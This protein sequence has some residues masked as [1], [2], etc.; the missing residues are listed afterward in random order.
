LLAVDLAE[1]LE[2]QLGTAWLLGVLV[3]GTASQVPKGSWILE[4]STLAM[5]NGGYVDDVF[6]KMVK[7]CRCGN[8]SYGLVGRD[9]NCM[10]PAM[11][12]AIAPD[13]HVRRSFV[14]CH[15]SFTSHIQCQLF[16]ACLG[17]RGQCE[18]Q[19]SVCLRSILS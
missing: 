19:D 18:G 7:G 17:T 15:R 4:R 6:D 3:F 2:P 16:L 9:E 14:A 10:Q 11:H 5:T 12:A 13:M 8:A 1:A